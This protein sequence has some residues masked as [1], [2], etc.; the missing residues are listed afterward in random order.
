M[1]VH[2]QVYALILG[3]VFSASAVVAQTDTGIRVG[4]AAGI[5]QALK[6]GQ[7]VSL[8]ESFG[9]WEVGLLNDGEIGTHSIVEINNSYFVL[10]DLAQVTRFWVPTTSI[11]A[12]TWI[13]VPGLSRPKP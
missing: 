7:R 12:V 11:K 1:N 6:V 4:G 9:Q 10:M 2:K 8:K 3:I 5:F 13:K